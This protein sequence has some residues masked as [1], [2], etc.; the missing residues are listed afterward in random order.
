MTLLSL[1]VPRSW[2]ATER[3]VPAPLLQDRWGKHVGR[4][5]AGMNVCVWEGFLML[6]DFILI[7]PLS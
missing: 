7:T 3:T 1:S 5:V 4:G 2:L 6:I